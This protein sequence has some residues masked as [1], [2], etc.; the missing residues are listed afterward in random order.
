M[1]ADPLL[2]HAELGALTLA[3]ASPVA[4]VRTLA[5]GLRSQSRGGKIMALRLFVS[6]LVEQEPSIVEA[7]AADLAALSGPVS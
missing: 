1:I 6:L 7:I 3:E 5:R 4:A 2:R